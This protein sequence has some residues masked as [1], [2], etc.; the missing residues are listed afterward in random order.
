MP[1]F[2]L[3]RTQVMTDYFQMIRHKQI[4]FPRWEDFEPFAMDILNINTEYDEERGKVRYTNN[5]PDDFFQALVYG[6]ETAKRHQS[7]A[8]EIY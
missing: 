4:I 5:D 1:A 6:G 8:L 2:T 7:A 3:N